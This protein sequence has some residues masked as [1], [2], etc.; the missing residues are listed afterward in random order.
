MT[1]TPP[2]QEPPEPWEQPPYPTTPPVIPLFEERQI[3]PLPQPL[4]PFQALPP[5]PARYTPLVPTLLA[6]NIPSLSDLVSPR[7]REPVD[8]NYRRNLTTLVNK[9]RDMSQYMSQLPSPIRQSLIN[10]DAER[11]AL[12]SQ[13]LTRNETFGAAQS[14]VLDEPF[15]PE[16]EPSPFNV[17]GNIKS[18]LGLILQS[19]PRLLN[20][21]TYL[22]EL[23][24]MQTF[25]QSGQ[26]GDLADILQAPGFRL[27]PGAFAAGEVLEGRPETLAQHPLFT[28]LDVLPFA[29][30]AA[31]RTPVAKVQ[32]ARAQEQIRQGRFL[33]APRPI[34]TVLTRR[35]TPAGEVEPNVLGRGLDALRTQTRVGQQLESF[36]GKLAREVALM[37]GRRD[38]RMKALALGIGIPAAIDE[39]LLLRAATILDNYSDKYPF[40]KRNAKGRDFDRQRAEFYD[41][42]RSNPEK[43]DPGLVDELR[44]FQYDAGMYNVQQSILGFFDKEFYDLKVAKKLHTAQNIVDHSNVMVQMRN[45]LVSPSGNL[46]AGNIRQWQEQIANTTN[47]TL[48]EEAQRT[49]DGVLDAHQI[50]PE[51]LFVR[52]PDLIGPPRPI[53]A[54]TTFTPRRNSQELITVL[55]EISRVNPAARRRVDEQVGQLIGALRDRTRRATVSTTLTNLSRRKPAWFPDDL[56]PAFRAD[57]QSLARRVTLDNKLRTRYTPARHQVR[58]NKLDRVTRSAAPARFHAKLI[59]EWGT[60]AP[61]RLT[62]AAEIAAGHP[63]SPEQVASIQSAVLAKAWRDIPGMTEQE[64]ITIVRQTEKEVIRTWKDIRDELGP[65]EQPVFIHKVSPHRAQQTLGTKLGIVPEKITQVRERAFDLTPEVR[66]LRIS[67]THQAKE[68]LGKRYSEDFIDE[69]IGFVGRTEGQLRDELR[70][71]AE[72]R[73]ERFPGLDVN[74]HLEEIIKSRYEKFNPEKAGFSW[75][76]ARLAKYDQTT[77]FIPKAIANNLHRRARPE[78]IFSTLSDPLTK[79]FRYNVIGLSPS[80]IVNN[81]FS[82]MVAQTLEIGPT[83]LKYFREANEWF[84]HPERIPNEQLKAMN[85]AETPFL[86]HLDREAWMQTTT[87]Q[88]FFAGVNASNAFHD[89]AFWTAYNRSHNVKEALD[90]VVQKSLRAQQWGDNVYRNM[91]YMYALEKNL[92]IPGMTRQ[93]AEHTAM[94]LVRRTFVDYAQFTPIERSALRTIIPFYSYMSH[95]ARLVLRYPLNHPVRASVGAAIAR[96]EK[97]RL[98]ALPGSFLSMFPLSA[99]S[100]TGSQLWMS[101]RPFSP[102]QDHADL[103]SFSGW[104]AAMNPGIQIALTQIGVIRGEADLYP[105][106]RYDPETGRMKAVQPGLLSETI[107]SVLP[108]VNVLLSLAGL[109][110]T[111]NEIRYRD[112]DAAARTLASMAGLPRLWREFQ[113]PQEIAKAEVRRQRTAREVLANALRTGN[114]REALT[115]PSLR[116][117]LAQYGNLTPDQIEAMQAAEPEAIVQALEGT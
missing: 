48:R 109:N 97:E 1:L 60:L 66:D 72:W 62:E 73:A 94:E 53:P 22:N 56:F 91:T 116:P 68:L 76:G 19:I 24:D 40:L 54:D 10:M 98:G 71:H 112:P 8:R 84:Q 85:V 35:L 86:E 7:Q 13:P 9:Y 32:K 99:I 20:P 42:I 43:W 82:N 113:V 11:V 27:I 44:S 59:D 12:G 78:S 57:A 63:L 107:T 114:W 26:R 92:K 87:G 52:D 55:R 88:R 36:G 106:L 51:D 89:S 77:Y 105:T 93:Q 41:S 33:Q 39:K 17:L 47:K 21:V 75:G 83:S 67:L 28:F 103:L 80:I 23:R 102:F 37:A 81:F 49:L 101:L 25:L 18:D 29:H 110:P 4:Q 58:V 31:A 64:V 6:Q 111:Y 108:R 61:Q 38:Q 96:A 70:Q 65:A 115:Y 34:S 30:A 74:G 100:P 50:T 14:A 16:A 117:L 3:G 5:D 95:A 69:V 15:T 104:M 45:E 2:I 90:T 79:V 46:T